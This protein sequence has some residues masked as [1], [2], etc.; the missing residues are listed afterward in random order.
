MLVYGSRVFGEVVKD[1]AASC[2][3]E[4][5]GFIDDRH[6]GAGI[7]GD[8][9]TVR[10]ACPASGYSLAIAVGYRHLPERREL[11][12]RARREGYAMPALVHPRAYVRDREA[13]G[14]GAFIM[15]GAVV[16]VGASIGD[17]AVIW[18]GAT[19]N[20]HSVIGANTFVSPNAAVCGKTTVGDDCFIGAGAVIVDHQDVP[21]GSFV[22]AGAVHGRRK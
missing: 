13:I 10:G 7:V 17:F 12:M 8:W 11:W 6:T 21:S 9:N 4:F 16:D 1:L 18:P 22:K 20:H 14:E 5:S 19:I 15:A 3:Y 2:G